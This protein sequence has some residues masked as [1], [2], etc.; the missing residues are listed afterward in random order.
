MNVVILDSRGKVWEIPPN[1]VGYF[2]VLKHIVNDNHLPPYYG[3]RVATLI[4]NGQVVCTDLDERARAYMEELTEKMTAVTQGV[5]NKH[6]PV[7]AW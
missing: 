3:R 1:V 7:W 6:K 4:I 5:Q 2:Q